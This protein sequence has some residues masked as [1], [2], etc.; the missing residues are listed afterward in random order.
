MY[1]F[2]RSHTRTKVRHLKLAP[3]CCSN[4]FGSLLVPVLAREF[5]R[6]LALL[7]PVTE[8]YALGLRVWV[9]SSLSLSLDR[10]PTVP[11]TEF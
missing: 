11:A 10:P 5:A 9:L 2:A 3:G 4:H 7:V 1:Q 6:R 8:A